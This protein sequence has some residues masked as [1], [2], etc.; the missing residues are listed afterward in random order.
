M[1]VLRLAALGR[2][3]L[4]S[5]DVGDAENATAIQRSRESSTPG[6]P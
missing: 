4:I 1:A 3:V 5:F 6:D 2:I